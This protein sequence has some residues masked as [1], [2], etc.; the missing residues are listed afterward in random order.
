MQVEADWIDESCDSDSQFIDAGDIFATV[1]L[2]PSWVPI[3]KTETEREIGFWNAAL[4][5]ALA[6]NAAKH[7]TFVPAWQKALG[8]ALK[9]RLVDLAPTLALRGVASALDKLWSEFKTGAPCKAGPE[10]A[11]IFKN[12][13]NNPELIEI[14]DKDALK[15][16][17]GAA[18][19]D[20]IKYLQFVIGL[21]RL[22]Q[23]N[24]K[25]EYKLNVPLAYKLAKMA[26][27]GVW[28]LCD[29][30]ALALQ[31]FQSLLNAVLGTAAPKKYL[32][33][34]PE[35]EAAKQGVKRAIQEPE[36]QP[37]PQPQP[38]PQQ[39]PQPQPQPRP[40]QPPPRQ[41]PPP[42]AYG[43]I[44]AGGTRPPAT[45]LPNP[46]P[47]VGGYQANP[48]GRGGKPLPA[49]PS[50]AAPPPPVPRPGALMSN[51]SFLTKPAFT[52]FPK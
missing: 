45:Q 35:P 43:P 44:P 41:L 20:S 26:L 49:A 36:S 31:H 48:P 50:P 25:R 7:A 1:P 51:P 37:K 16:I 12:Y 9:A 40:Q 46:P 15:Q 24:P 2:A 8:A 18:I 22:S 47:T 19:D 42:T 30:P 11:K 14:D 6:V 28:L 3:G 5:F 32:F 13:F 29:R 39:P 21:L 27:V 38:Q 33:E 52:R 17:K 10:L 34:E 23:V 4:Q